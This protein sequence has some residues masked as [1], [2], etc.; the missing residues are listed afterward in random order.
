MVLELDG[1][2]LLRLRGA[3]GV[4]IRVLDGAVWITEPGCEGD[5]FVAGGRSYRVRG[6]GLVVV[7]AE[8]GA[9]VVL[10][11]ASAGSWLSRL[12]RLGEPRVSLLSD[13]MLRDIGLRREQLR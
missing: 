13:R 2:D 3:Q 4:A 10:R 11:G 6:R 12:L 1:N 8:G 9:R 7:G 5:A